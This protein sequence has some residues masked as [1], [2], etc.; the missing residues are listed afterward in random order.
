MGSLHIPCLFLVSSDTQGM[1]ISLCSD[2]HLKVSAISTT[3]VQN[4]SQPAL[5]GAQL[6]LSPSQVR[7]AVCSPPGD[8]GHRTGFLQ[9]KSDLRFL[10]F[11]QT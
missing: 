3:G 6:K 8:P 7:T 9:D 10:P 5:S 11:T 4:I 1:S 2:E